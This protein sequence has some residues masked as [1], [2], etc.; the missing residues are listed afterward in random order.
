[1]TALLELL[2]GPLCQRIGWT[3]VHFLWQGAAVA[4]VLAIALRL[5]RGRTPQ[6]RW[7]TACAALAIM[8]ALPGVTVWVTGSAPPEPAA[9]G[10]AARATVEP[11]PYPSREPAPAP[12]QAPP[13]I[14]AEAAPLPAAVPAAPDIAAA[15]PRQWLPALE[16]LLRPMLP[17]AVLVWLAGVAGMSLRHAGG[18]AVLARLRRA[19]TCSP[20]PAVATAFDRLAR[21]LGVRRAARVLASARVA[22][23]IV[24]GWLRPVVLLPVSALSGLT[25]GQV[26]AVLAHELAH[27]RRHDGL[28]R[29]FQA[30]VETVLFYHP[31]VWWVSGRIR[32]ESE[33]CCDDLAVSVCGDRH[34]YADALIRA[35]ELGR[36]RPRLAP[37]ATGGELA[38]RV[39]RL[40]GLPA[41]DAARANRW[42]AGV[43]VVAS[44]AVAGALLCGHTDT[45]V[46]ADPQ[47]AGEDKAT[48]QPEE[49]PGD[50]LWGATSSAEA[51]I[52]ARIAALIRQLGSDNFRDREEAQQELVTIGPAAVDALQAAAADEDAERASRAETTLAEI[53]RHVP[54]S[55]NAVVEH[56]LKSPAV[57]RHQAFVDLDTG[58]I[59]P[60]PGSLDMADRKALWEWAR[61]AGVDAVA[62]TS[63]AI[64]GLRGFAMVLAKVKDADWSDVNSAAAAIA[65]RSFL[66]SKFPVDDPFAQHVA[67]TNTVS[68][69]PN[70]SRTYA[71]RTRE[72]AMGL[73]QFLEFSDE[74][75]GMVR[76]RY[77]ILRRS[78]GQS[79]TQPAA[80][81][82]PAGTARLTFL[83][84][85]P[86]FHELD[87]SITEERLKAM[88]AEKGLLVTVNEGGALRSYRLFRKDGENVIVMFRTDGT[89]AG[90]QRMRKD[91]ER[92]ARAAAALQEILDRAWTGPAD[93]LQVRLRPL[94]S[95]WAAGKTPT[96][97]L[98]LRNAGKEVLSFFPLAGMHCQVEVHGIW[99]TWAGG[100]DWS[101]PASMLAPGK[102]ARDVIRVDLTGPWTALNKERT[103]LTLAA[104]R[105]TI[106]VRFRANG[107]KEYVASNPVV[108]EIQGGA[109]ATPSPR[110]RLL[111]EA[112]RRIREGLL[113]LSGQFPQLK[114]A[115]NRPLAE[116]LGGGASPPG[117]LSI[118]LGRAN[119]PQKAPWKAEPIEDARTWSFMVILEELPDDP[120]APPRQAMSI[121]R[122]YPNLNL[123]GQQ[124]ARAGDPKLDAALKKLLAEAVAPLKAMDE[125]VGKKPPEPTDAAGRGS[126]A[127]LLPVTAAYVEVGTAGSKAARAGVPK[128]ISDKAGSQGLAVHAV[129]TWQELPNSEKYSLIY[130]NREAVC[131]RIIERHD[132][133]GAVLE[134]STKVSRASRRIT[135]RPGV[136]RRA[137]I[138]LQGRDAV[139]VCLGWDGQ[140]PSPVFARAILVH[141]PAGT[142]RGWPADL[143]GWVVKCLTQF[144]AVGCEDLGTGGWTELGPDAKPL[145]PT[146]D[147]GKVGAGIV[148][149]DRNAWVTAYAVLYGKDGQLR[150]DEAGRPLQKVTTVQP[151]IPGNKWPG[152]ICSFQRHDDEA[153][154]VAVVYHY[155]PVGGAAPRWEPKTQPAERPDLIPA[156]A[157]TSPA[158][159]QA[160]AR[161]P[162][163]TASLELERLWDELSAADVVRADKAVVVM[164]E[165]GDRAVA[166]LAGRLLPAPA[167][168]EV[169]RGLVARLDD[170]RFAVRKQAEDELAKT[171]R[172]A[173]PA[174]G[175]ILAE[176][177]LSAEARAAVQRLVTNMT[178]PSAD[179]PEARRLGNA[180][181]VLADAGTGAAREC[182]AR[183]AP[184][185]WFPWGKPTQGIRCRLRADKREWK[186]EEDPTFRADLRNTG[187]REL[188]LTVVR[189]WWELQ[190][191]GVWYENTHHDFESL[192]RIDRR[193]FGPGKQAGDMAVSLGEAWGWRRKDS[194]QPLAV[195][196]G[197]HTIRV[198]YDP[199]ENRLAESNAV[200]IEI[201]PDASAVKRLGF[202]GLDLTDG[203]RTTRLAELPLYRERPPG[204]GHYE[205]V[206]GVQVIP[207]GLDG[208]IYHLP[209]SKVFYVQHDPPASSTRTFYG[210][211][212]GDPAKRLK[213]EEARTRPA[214]TP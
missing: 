214:L 192:G 52:D 206:D 148:Q 140:A 7:A 114:T 49:R 201:Q 5:L 62:D 14:A 11:V 170:G 208:T 101:G 60:V 182:L 189:D 78:G 103:P 35:A 172:A 139:S 180:L 107:Q 51:G 81:S 138:H 133:G 199:P 20:G 126:R 175:K 209:K 165:M 79:G 40:L 137:F 113:T 15:P 36:A 121:F 93:G 85:V 166:F 4:G 127:E 116:A 196:P 19:D 37:A 17:W 46:A 160:D 104:G 155:G 176:G 186:P 125:R 32:A 89:C 178:D 195:K 77:K 10:P 59:I 171:G 47:A 16:G 45:T 194:K 69:D 39:R 73:L 111:D 207:A 147:G 203:P 151:V 117:Y 28:V 161:V 66:D 110:D 88:I 108:I 38:S 198:A 21:R 168:A 30:V 42:L 143:P 97:S 34:G 74:P 68:T 3:L 142:R 86:E 157:M 94:R 159:P 53:R 158:D 120:Q 98:D 43:L 173:L 55:V 75:G 70:I 67:T 115:N 18:W 167:D 156:E 149:R 23:P 83:Q 136:N 164:A 50:I 193:P 119:R 102:E 95:V 41:H 80:P 134:A 1:M 197:R 63:Q 90:V 91:P 191:D 106:R 131:C 153:S 184:E 13:A 96:L 162:R 202:R 200:V 163:A 72:G 2:S 181:Q 99:H 211:F 56:R 33:S 185:G 141:G 76:F 82:A 61:S 118:W 210:P 190:C 154:Y 204:S 87:R 122:L 48:T 112:G 213:L 144:R 188:T 27:I 179:A 6:A 146:P 65:K 169:V 58:R 29:T 183:A 132:D 128:W 123:G 205:L 152:R 12:L 31:A 71:F 84:D 130:T 44:L 177:R 9:M 54:L 150:R 145:G 124:S 92:A 109:V 100:L 64:R 212:A 26:E 174:L 187:Q 8:A 25:P 57:S 105:H 22:V 135:L 129:S 24:V